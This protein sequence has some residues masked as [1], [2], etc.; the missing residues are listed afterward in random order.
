MKYIYIPIGNTKI[1]RLIIPRFYEQVNELEHTYVML[2]GIYNVII[3][4]EKS[5]AAP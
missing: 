5:L 3:I 1:K 2:M 4:L